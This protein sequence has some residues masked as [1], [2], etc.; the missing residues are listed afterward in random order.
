MTSVINREEFLSKLQMVQAGLSQKEIIQ[1]SDCFV[2]EDGVIRTFN[3]EIACTVKSDLSEDFKGAIRAAPLLAMLGKLKSETLDLEITESELMI[4]VSS[5]EWTKITL[6][7]EITL[8]IPKIPEPK[9]WVKLPEGFGEAVDMVISCAGNDETKFM[10]T[11]VHLCDKWIEASDNFQIARVRMELGM[12]D[13]CLIRKDAIKHLTSLGVTKFSEAEAWIHFKSPS[14]VVLSC[15]RYL[16]DYP[17]YA[18]VLKF[19]GAPASL[20]RGLDEIVEKAEIFSAEDSDNNNVIVELTK[21][22]MVIRSVGLSGEYYKRLKLPTYKG[23]EMVFTIAPKLLSEISKRHPDCEI[24][25][26]RL[27]IKFGKL[28][29]VTCLGNLDKKE[30]EDG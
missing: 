9:K 22:K 21:G 17:S 4:K 13:S 16:Q 30:S 8:A 28:T 18:K 29:Y 15:R 27:K 23:R 10:L 7:K 24:G 12:T 6:M 19:D 14:G 5:T 11:C 26:E 1:Q 2:F 3:D 25:E 20:P